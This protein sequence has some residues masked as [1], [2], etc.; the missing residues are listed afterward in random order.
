M[1]TPTLEST[2]RSSAYLG[3]ADLNHYWGNRSWALDASFAASFL[4]GSEAA[5]SRVQ[6]TSA[7][8]YQRP[9]ADEVRFD[10]TRTSLNGHAAQIALTKTSGGHWGGN[11]AYQEKSPGYETN[12]IGFT[13]T[14]GRRGISTDLHYEQTRPGPLFRNYVIGIL[15]GNDWNFDGDHT[16]NYI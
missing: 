12:D 8:Y 1:D 4:N 6:R 7:R 14:V 16:T 9:D 13:G 2:L 15:S 10:S 3:G 11:V 5:I